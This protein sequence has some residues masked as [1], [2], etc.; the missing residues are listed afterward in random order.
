MENWE[1]WN[2]ILERGG[3]SL[4]SLSSEE[5]TIYRVNCFL[6]DAEG[7]LSGF[8]YNISPPPD[9]NNWSELLETAAA[10]EAV[11]NAV[12]AATLRELADLLL[13]LPSRSASTWV[14]FLKPV[15]QELKATFEPQVE[16]CINELWAQ[17]GAFTSRTLKG[18]KSAQ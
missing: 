13:R 9:L 10:V 14:D 8:L 18:S 2:E 15:E 4:A 16:R 12:C 1:I 6:T 17:L 3:V 7:G 5:R 11:G